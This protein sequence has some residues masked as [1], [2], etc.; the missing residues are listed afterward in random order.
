[1]R[2]ASLSGRRRAA[3]PMPV[4]QRTSMTIEVKPALW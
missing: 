2:F 3:L 1:M 4:M